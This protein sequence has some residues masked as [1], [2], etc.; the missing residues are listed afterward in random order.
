MPKYY[1]HLHDDFDS[2]DV[3]GVELPDLSA[4]RFCAVHS[5]RFTASETMKALGHFIPSHRIDIEDV[6]GTVLDSVYFRDAVKIG[7]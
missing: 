7:M 5:A 6:H 3:E 1:F 4:A 2:P